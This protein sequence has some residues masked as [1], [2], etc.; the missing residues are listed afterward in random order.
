MLRPAAL[1]RAGICVLLL[2]LVSCAS[3][4][5]PSGDDSATLF[6]VQR[7]SLWGFIDRSGRVAIEPQFDRAWH[8]S[9][10]RALVRID[11]QYGYIDST[12][13]RVIA[14][15]FRDA[16]HF[17]DGLAPVQR[18][19]LWGFIDRSGSEVVD[20]RF[21][22]APGVLEETPADSAYRRARVEGQYGYRTA[23][24]SLVIAPRFEQAWSFSEG[25]ARVRQDGQWG[26][27]NREGQIVIEP[28][29]EHAWDFRNGLARVQTSDGTLGYVDRQ[30]TRVWPPQ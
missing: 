2:G 23:D 8:F 9:D 26:F 4:S 1:P 12:G 14:P 29:F 7:D 20:A 21:D 27:I 10:G 18:D 16:W 17:S 13:A 25:L 19:S 3:P 30:G 24:D 5:S 11:E 15:R 28:Q 22:L 6:P